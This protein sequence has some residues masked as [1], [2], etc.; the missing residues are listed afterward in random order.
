MTISSNVVSKQYW[1]DINEGTSFSYGDY[2][3]TEKE[4]IEFASQ[5]DPFDFHVDPVKANESPLGSLIAS[6][7]H[8]LAIKQRLTVKHVYSTWHVFAGKQIANC[9][10]VRPVYPNDTLSV[11]LVVLETTE[12]SQPDRGYVKINFFVK[13]QENKVVLNAIGEIV[14]ARIPT[15][16]NA[17]SC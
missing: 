4:I 1:E 2:L 5:Y 16:I 15:K 8:T 6:G 9:R 14:I 10:F 3:V 17:T 13:N 11:E 12:A 7:I